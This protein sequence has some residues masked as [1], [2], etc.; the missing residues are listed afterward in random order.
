MD[1]GRVVKEHFDRMA[2]DGSYEQFY[3]AED[4]RKTH[5]FIARK[6]RV[7]ELLSPHMMPKQRVLDLGCG[8]GPMVDFFCS[9][10]LYYC[11][12]DLA[13]S[14]LTS[15]EKKFRQSSYWP[16]IELQLGSSEQIPYPNANFDLTVAMG[17]L[18][19]LDD[20]Q[21]ALREIVRVTK[22]GGIAIL[23]VPNRSCLNRFVMRH[24]ASIT[25]LA[26]FFGRLR[27]HEVAQGNGIIHREFPPRALDRSVNELGF[28]RIGYAFYDYRL[29]C[30]P[31]TRAF[32][33]FAFAVNRRVENR[34][35]FFLANGYIGLYRRA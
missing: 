29:V 1:Q 23:T 24:S 17:L 34:A 20:F 31:V 7:E 22:P 16:A 12:V 8:T 2:Q 33:N 14:M 18:E 32:P 3:S 13:E 4:Q 11:G 6:I 10:G 9:R 27:G 15:I 28:K 5:D 30:Y 21:P 19:Y 35:P 25:H 26:R